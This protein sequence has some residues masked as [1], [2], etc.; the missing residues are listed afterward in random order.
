LHWLDTQRLR[1]APD[2]PERRRVPTS[3]Q[4]L[5]LRHVHVE[6]VSEILLRETSRLA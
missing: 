2:R 3:F 6:S 4:A 1:D 5:H